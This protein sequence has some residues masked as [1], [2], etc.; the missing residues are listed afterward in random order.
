MLVKIIKAES[1]SKYERYECA[2]CKESVPIENLQEH[3]FKHAASEKYGIQP[4]NETKCI[5]KYKSSYHV[6]CKTCEEVV[7]FDEYEEHMHLHEMD[8]KF[9]EFV[10]LTV[11]GY[12]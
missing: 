6:H 11:A 10:E 2:Q 12:G 9:A 1:P 3:L 8:N 7:R 5:R 4:C